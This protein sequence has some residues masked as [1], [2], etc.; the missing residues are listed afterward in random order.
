MCISLETE[1]ETQHSKVQ[2]TRSSPSVILQ[3][4]PTA[5]SCLG[6]RKLALWALRMSSLSNVCLAQWDIENPKG[7]V[8][9]RKHNK[10]CS[11]V[12]RSM[13]SHWSGIY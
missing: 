10:K 6:K 5:N 11:H 1:L 7:S 4:D 2:G 9:E 3:S 13:G 12:K 8:K